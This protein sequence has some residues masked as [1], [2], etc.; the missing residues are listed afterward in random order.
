M[1]NTILSNKLSAEVSDHN[2]AG[3]RSNDRIGARPRSSASLVAMDGALILDGNAR[4]ALAATRSL[5]HRGVRVVVA[6]E[7]YK[8]MAS[9]SKY[10]SAS[11]RYPSPADHPADFAAAVIEECRQRNLGVIFPMSEITTTI[12]LQHRDQFSQFRVP[13][14]QSHAFEML[15]DKSKLLRLANRLNIPV[16]KTALVDGVASLPSISAGLRFPAVLKPHRSRIWSKGRWI[17]ASVQYVN[18]FQELLETAAKHE[19][20]S[21]HPFLIQEYISGEAQ[22]LFGLYRQGVP[23]AFFAHRRLRENPP[24][25]GVS[26]LSESIELCPKILEMA[27]ALLEHVGWHG[28]AMVEFK[29]SSNGTPYLM[30]VNARFW[31]SLQLAIDAGVDFPWLLYQ[32]VTGRELD[33]IDTYRVG[34]RSR[35]LL[36]DLASLVKLLT[37]KGS[38]LPTT[39]LGKVRSVVNFLNLPSGRCRYDV[40]RWDDLR[41]FL[42]ELSRAT[43]YFRN[44]F[45][46]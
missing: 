38:P 30:E 17:S 36:G 41:P 18:S 26:V 42:Y 20:F 13:F 19:Y 8:T 5:G 2:R 25:G 11:F 28:V 16:P 1:L 45:A 15:N 21:E 10:S 44:R 24:S 39:W 3:A 4:S 6:D 35:W 14:V 33:R 31:G 9:G 23:V 27:R 43:S 37:H 7:T 46:C 40:N 22:G 34:I 32:M 29:V 12:M